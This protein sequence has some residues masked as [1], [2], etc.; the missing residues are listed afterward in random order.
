MLG[1]PR[2]STVLSP[3]THNTR[4][5]R[6]HAA[7]ATRRPS[8][9]VATDFQLIAQALERDHSA[10]RLWLRQMPYDLQLFPLRSVVVPGHCWVTAYTYIPSAEQVIDCCQASAGAFVLDQVAPRSMLR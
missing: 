9:L 8:A 4:T 3:C 5:P 7:A 2:S 1:M 6:P 10:P